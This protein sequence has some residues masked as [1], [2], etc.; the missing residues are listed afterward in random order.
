MIEATPY[1]DLMWNPEDLDKRPVIHLWP[2]RFL[3]LDSISRVEPND[4]FPETVHLYLGY[5]EFKSE[6]PVE[7]SYEWDDWL[8]RVKEWHHWVRSGKLGYKLEFPDGWEYDI[9]T[10][11]TWSVRG[12]DW[13]ESLDEP[14]AWNHSGSGALPW[15]DIT[16]FDDGETE[17]ST[18]RA[19]IRVGP[20]PIVPLGAVGDPR[21][22]HA[23][24][25]PTGEIKWE[26]P[27][28]R[29]EDYEKAARIIGIS[30]DEVRTRIAT[31]S[32]KM[33]EQYRG[34]P[35]DDVPLSARYDALR[36]WGHIRKPGS[37]GC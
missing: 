13:V 7:E 36:R 24:Q 14:I 12:R 8:R 15:L 4:E 28:H 3:R 11:D 1:P 10:G 25:F 21:H 18:R 27:S 37:A 30:V 31:A 33:R 19:T 32:E 34:H 9:P 35:A 5:S 26:R 2:D 22:I 23:L 16:F 17:N 29:D 6:P 20:I